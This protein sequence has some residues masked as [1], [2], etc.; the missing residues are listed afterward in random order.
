MRCLS[1]VLLHW[2]IVLE[3]HLLRR[4][5]HDTLPR[6]TSSTVNIFYVLTVNMP[7]NAFMAL[8]EGERRAR[9]YLMQRFLKA[10]F[11]TVCVATNLWI[12]YQPFAL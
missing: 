10:L 9:I 4:T 6:L 1:K 12:S 2:A 11:R 8:I 5:L 7:R 3:T